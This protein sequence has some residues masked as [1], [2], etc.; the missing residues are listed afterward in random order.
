MKRFT[1]DNCIAQNGDDALNF[2]KTHIYNSSKVLF[3]GTVGLDS[4]SIYYPILLGSS[5]SIEYKF[6]IEKRPVLSSS[7]EDLGK[8]HKDFLIDNLAKCPIE[9]K[10][11]VI[12]AE[13]GATVA[14]RNAV[15]IVSEW[16]QESDF[17]DIIIDTTGMSRGTCFPIVNQAIQLG[18]MNDVNVHMLVASKNEPTLELVSESNDRAEW[19]HGFQGDMGR[20]SMDDALK[21][22][23][24]QL[25]EG[26][27]QAAAFMYSALS[28][29]AE[30][31]P[32]IPFPSHN[33]R[34]GDNILFEYKDA[35]TEQWDSGLLNI[36]YAHEANPLDV[37][38][39]VSNIHKIREEVF[40]GTGEKPVTVLSPSGWRI[41]S[42]GMLLASIDLKLPILY[43]ETLGYNA[44]SVTV[45]DVTMPEPDHTWHIWLTGN[46]Y[47]KVL[48]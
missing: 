20:D 17:S 38:R 46:A 34:R 25:S 2:L 43:V 28:P 32:I 41:G 15:R 6:L 19:M 18:L 21:L 24:P 3:I 1:L 9:F 33:P 36:V 8:A 40:A 23:I 39:S 27:G 26:K 31:C 47:A 42:L 4:N 13:D 30:V 7:L 16:L 45:S 48:P 44:S 11:V 37:Y 10:E 29:V 35:L 14:G 12:I 22:W 5:S